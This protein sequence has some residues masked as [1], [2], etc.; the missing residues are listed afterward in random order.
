[1]KI[2]SGSKCVDTVAARNCFLVNQLATPGLGSLMAGRII[3]GFG[4]VIVAVAGFAMVMVWFV[5]TMI[6]TY[7]QF[8]ENAP[9]KSYAWFGEAGALIFL[10]AWLWSLVTSISLWRHAKA[11]ERGPQSTVPPRINDV[12]GGTAQK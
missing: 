3:T 9:E 8:T 6:H 2:F 1:M 5:L 11:A 7:Q 4:Q 10:A 12:S